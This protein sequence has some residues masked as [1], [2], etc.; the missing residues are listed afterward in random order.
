MSVEFDDFFDF[1]KDKKV[2]KP[3]EKPVKKSKTKAKA[4]QPSKSTTPKS[5]KKEEGKK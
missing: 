4:I 2:K 5:K 1:D 3:V